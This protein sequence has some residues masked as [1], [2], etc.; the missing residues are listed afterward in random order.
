MSIHV[1]IN[2]LLIILI[3]VTGIYIGIAVHGLIIKDNFIITVQEGYNLKDVANSLWGL[4]GINEKY[5]VGLKEIYIGEFKEIFPDKSDNAG[6]YIASTIY[7]KDAQGYVFK[8]ELAHHVYYKIL[9][10]NQRE[11]WNSLS[12]NSTYYVSDYAETNSQE[13]FAVSLAYYWS[14]EVFIKSSCPELFDECLEKISLIIS[15]IDPEIISY[16]GTEIDTENI[17]RTLE[18]KKIKFFIKNIE[19]SQENLWQI[20][21]NIERKNI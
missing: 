11:E 18:P 16:N 1:G 12:K 17:T 6:L 8:H 7:I 5:S 10:K 14:N 20:E 13:D 4:E 15:Y 2:L 19:T 3:L 21:R 9:A